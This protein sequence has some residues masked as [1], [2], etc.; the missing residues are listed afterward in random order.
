MW[1]WRRSNIPMC[2]DPSGVSWPLRPITTAEQASTQEEIEPQWTTSNP[3]AKPFS[4]SQPNTP[5]R[6]IH[7]PPSPPPRRPGRAHR[8][9]SLP[10]RVRRG[11]TIGVASYSAR[12]RP[13]AR[14]GTAGTKVPVP[15]PRRPSTANTDICVCQVFRLNHRRNPPLCTG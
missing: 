11:P 6:C 14:A 3:R 1:P 5:K 9:P 8:A 15:V 7:C 2:V 4:K 12:R 13:R 10:A